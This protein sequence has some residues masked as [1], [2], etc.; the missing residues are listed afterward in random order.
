[1]DE[2]DDIPRVQLEVWSDVACPWCY[3][4]RRNLGVA[5]ADIDERERPTVTWRAYQLDPSVPEDG[6][7]A[8]E[9]FAARFGADLAKLEEGRER[10]VAIGEELGIDFRFDRQRTVPNTHLAHRVLQAAEQHGEREPLMDAIFAA[11]FEQ[12]VD[13]SSAEHLR[14]LVVDQLVDPDLANAIVDAALSDPDLAATVDAEIATAGELGITGV[15]CFVADRRIAVPGA[16]PPP[17]LAQ[18]IAEAGQRVDDAD[19]ASDTD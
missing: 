3:V 13:I 9:Y 8:D 4:G 16:V 2:V 12:G 1:M 19:E 15:P 5:L 11:Y 14:E 10:L 6:T 17:V 18:L 7:E